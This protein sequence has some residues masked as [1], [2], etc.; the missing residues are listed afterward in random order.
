RYQYLADDFDT[1]H[2]VMMLPIMS[3]TYHDMDLNG[4]V[5]SAKSNDDL[6]LRM[7]NV[8]TDKEFERFKRHILQIEQS[9]GELDEARTKT[10]LQEVDHWSFLHYVSFIV[11]HPHFSRIHLKVLAALQDYLPDD[12]MQTWQDQATKRIEAQ[13]H[14]NEKASQASE[15][16]PSDKQSNSDQE[17]DKLR[18]Q[19]LS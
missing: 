1:D 15:Q 16:Q 18:E 5:Y 17:A 9:Q 14:Q 19:A 12:V 13:V 6:F 4:M 11:H 10:L 7:A 2:S 8:M 3:E